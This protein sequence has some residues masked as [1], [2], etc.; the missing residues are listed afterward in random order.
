MAYGKIRITYHESKN[1]F[2]LFVDDIDISRYATSVKIEMTAVDIP[3]VWVKLVG[4]IEIPDDIKA[5]I[6]VENDDPVS[7]ERGEFLRE[8]FGSFG[9]I[10]TPPTPPP[11]NEHSNV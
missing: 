5:M 1:R 8:H 3:Q 10:K 7:R 2:N 4:R 9:G 6:T 11:D